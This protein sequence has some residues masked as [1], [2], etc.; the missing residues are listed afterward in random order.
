MNGFPGG[1]HLL[2]EVGQ[3]GLFIQKPWI[4]HVLLEQA[5]GIGVENTLAD[6]LI[7][8][9]SRIDDMAH[10]FGSV[11]TENPLSVEPAH[12]EKDRT[13]SPLVEMMKRRIVKT[14]AAQIRDIDRACPI[15]INLGRY[16]V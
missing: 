2:P 14:D 4:L 12:R 3:L 11:L 7:D 1:L 6:S 9:D 13:G 10:T 16:R 8:T 5:Y 15:A